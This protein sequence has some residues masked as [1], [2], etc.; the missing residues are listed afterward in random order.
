MRGRVLGES[1]VDRRASPRIV[2]EALLPLAG[3]GP[4]GR[5]A[6]LRRD[7]VIDEAL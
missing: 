7:T 4:A 2:V 3:G 6:V 5:R 1:T